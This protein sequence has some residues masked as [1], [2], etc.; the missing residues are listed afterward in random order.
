MQTGKIAPKDEQGTRPAENSSHRE[1]IRYSWLFCS[2]SRIE[3]RMERKLARE[4][5]RKNRNK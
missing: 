5:R 1:E 4:E 3:R 2:R